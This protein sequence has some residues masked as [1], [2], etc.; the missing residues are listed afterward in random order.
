MRAEEVKDAL[1]RR[2]P[3]LS[4]GGG[5]IG[6]EVNGAGF[7]E[8]FLDRDGRIV[9]VYCTPSSRPRPAGNACVARLSR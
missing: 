3:A 5:M 4:P 2:H 1:R 9:S 6:H 8:V 7:A